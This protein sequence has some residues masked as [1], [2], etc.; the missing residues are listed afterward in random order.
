MTEELQK[1]F[2]AMVR[3]VVQSIGEG[4]QLAN[5]VA[6]VL[7]AMLEHLP[8]FLLFLLVCSLPVQTSLPRHQI[9]MWFQDKI[10]KFHLVLPACTCLQ[11]SFERVS[12]CC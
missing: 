9:L 11:L 3:D 5:E 12:D 7:S 1:G 6:Q 2:V 4:M 8:S 10:L